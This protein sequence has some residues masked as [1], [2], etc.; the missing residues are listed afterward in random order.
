[1]DFMLSPENKQF[2]KDTIKSYKKDR[3]V[4]VFTFTLLK[5]CDKKDF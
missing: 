2:V 1:M 4:L 5:I 3:F